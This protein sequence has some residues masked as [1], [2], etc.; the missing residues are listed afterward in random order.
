MTEDVAV[1][2]QKNITIATI[3]GSCTSKI[4]PLDMCLNKPFKNNCHSQWV[5]FMQQQVAQQEPG[6]RLKLASKQQVVDWVVQSNKLLDSKKEIVWKSF[7]VCGISNAL[8]GSKNHFIRCAKEL[9]DMANA[10]V[11]EKSADRDSGSE[12]DDPFDSDSD[13]GSEIESDDET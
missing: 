7:L 13:S 5:A 11:L 8:D 12:S 3:P 6:E 10:Y 9:P 1:E 2:L 4:Q